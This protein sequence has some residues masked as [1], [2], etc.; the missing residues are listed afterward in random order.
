M[1]SLS[2]S[3]SAI[4]SAKQREESKPCV[5]SEI[6][7]E[8]VKGRCEILQSLQFA[9]FKVGHSNSTFGLPSPPH[10]IIFSI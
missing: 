6:P 7:I 1:F 9:P 4:A 8:R 2:S 3:L 10:P 5:I